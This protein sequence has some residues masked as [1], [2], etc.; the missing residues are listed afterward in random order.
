MSYI[1]ETLSDV[2]KNPVIDIYNH[3][4]QNGYAAF[5]EKQVSY[6]FFNILLE[7]INGYPSF[8][9]VNSSM[10]RVIGFCYLKAYHIFP[11]FKETAEIT[12]FIEPLEVGKGIGRMA[13]HKLENNGRAMEIRQILASVSSL[14]EQSLIFHLKNG[15]KECGRFEMIGKKMGKQFDVIWMQKTIIMPNLRI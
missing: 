5:P 13:L 1:F 9:I 14:N 15:F 6:E 2:H 11:V 12:C 10:K 4:I 7:K 8:A 3:Y